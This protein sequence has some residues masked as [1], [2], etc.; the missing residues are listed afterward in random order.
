MQHPFMILKTK[1]RILGK[2][3]NILNIINNILKKTYKKKQKATANIV[4]NSERLHASP[5]ILRKR[6]RYSLTM[7]I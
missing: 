7:S 6:Q 2:D 1:V 4:L 5:L 3:K